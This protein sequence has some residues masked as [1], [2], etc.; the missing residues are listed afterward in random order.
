MVDELPKLVTE[1]VFVD[2]SILVGANFNSTAYRT[3]IRL[4]T[5]GVV[6]LKTT[7]ITLNEIQQ[8]IATRSLQIK[9]AKTAILRNFEDFGE[10]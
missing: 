6:K 7:D 1:N 3:L 8:Q 2:T 9:D 10:L 5:L 4:S